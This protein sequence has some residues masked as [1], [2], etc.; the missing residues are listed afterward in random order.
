MSDFHAASKWVTGA[1][2]ALQLYSIT[3][4]QEKDCV[5]AI[6]IADN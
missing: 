1:P 6:M 3:L 2:F 5:I 4:T